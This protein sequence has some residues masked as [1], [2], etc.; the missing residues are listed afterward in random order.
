MDTVEVRHTSSPGER[1]SLR[2]I[3]AV[4]EREK[5]RYGPT[6]REQSFPANGVAQTPRS[7]K[8][9]DTEEGIS[10]VLLSV[11]MQ[12]AHLNTNHWNKASVELMLPDQT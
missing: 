2:E 10:C 4:C 5:E 12:T 6:E 9:E 8:K 3:K 7:V 1:L 11:S